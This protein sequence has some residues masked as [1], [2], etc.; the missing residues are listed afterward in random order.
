MTKML[1]AANHK[2]VFPLPI[3]MLF[4]V[5]QEMHAWAV[6]AKQHC[7]RGGE[8]G[9]VCSLWTRWLH[10]ATFKI[11]LKRLNSFVRGCRFQSE[12][13]RYFISNL[14]LCLRRWLFAFQREFCACNY[15]KTSGQL[16]WMD[17]LILSCCVF[18]EAC[19]HNGKQ[20]GANYKWQKL[21]G[22]DC[23]QCTCQENGSAN[24]ERVA[25]DACPKVRWRTLLDL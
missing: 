16:K 24:C 3:A 25:T 2:I 21:S 18:L 15:W 12:R 13:L 10:D 14:P 17:A 1:T 6:K 22:S 9:R 19:Y 20:M 7:T 11:A 5:T 8:G 4:P 23:I